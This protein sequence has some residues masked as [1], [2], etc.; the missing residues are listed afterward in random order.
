MDV[1]S[2]Y[3]IIISNQ[4]VEG[5]NPRHSFNGYEKR[6]LFKQLISSWD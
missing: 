2:R 1:P 3:G 5:R 4:K 6:Q